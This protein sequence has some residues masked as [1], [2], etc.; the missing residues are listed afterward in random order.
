MEPALCRWKWPLA[1]PVVLCTVEHGEPY[2]E[3]QKEGP[4]NRDEMVTKAKEGRI[5]GIKQLIVFSQRK[6]LIATP[7]DYGAEKLAKGME[8]TI[9]I[10]QS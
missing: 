9:L 8:K 1:A 6:G 4:N 5:T 10:F 2:P 3:L 7:V